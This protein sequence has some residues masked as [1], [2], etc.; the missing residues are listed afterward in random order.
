MK[1]TFHALICIL[2]LTI[3]LTFT[4]GAF[5]QDCVLEWW[6]DYS[7][8]EE[9]SHGNCNYVCDDI[10][11]FGMSPFYS[12]GTAA[13]AETFRTHRLHLRFSNISFLEPLI[14][15]VAVIQVM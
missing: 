13:T 5:A 10:G 14:L 9:C 1:K 7:E 2:S 3:T 6:T 11:P 15:V 8:C 4:A 12:V